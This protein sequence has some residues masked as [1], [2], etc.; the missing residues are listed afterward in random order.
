MKNILLLLIAAA[1]SGCGP[2]R[3][4]T[5]EIPGIDRQTF[6]YAVKEGK[7]LYL[8]RLVDSSAVIQGRRPVFI[9]SFSGA[10]EAGQRSETYPAPFLEFIARKGYVVAAIDYRLWI[11]EARQNNSLSEKSIAGDYMKALDM[12]VEDLFSAT[13]YI[14]QQQDSWNID[15][16]KIVA[17][18]FGSGAVNSLKAEY[19]ISTGENLSMKFLPDDFNYAGVISMAGA[20]WLPEGKYNM[21]WLKKPCPHM[22]VH[23]SADP[24][25]PFNESQAGGFRAYGPGFLLELFSKNGFPAWFYE[26]QQGNHYSASPAQKEYFQEINWFLERFVSERQNKVLHTIE[27][28]AVPNKI[29][30]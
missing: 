19:L 29:R 8:D 24:V 4:K 21:Q 30:Q 27:K 25:I 14:V 12:A 23:G 6:L 7:E 20:L 10:W 28:T 2:S 11:K 9:Y 26:I 13:S 5:A 3:K 22:F 1:V 18:G 17:G 15:P 16:L